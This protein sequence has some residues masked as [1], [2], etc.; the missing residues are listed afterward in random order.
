M[1]EI[2]SENSR[3]YII[4]EQIEFSDLAAFSQ[5]RQFRSEYVH[6]EKNIWV[7]LC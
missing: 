6:V 4:Q 5:I 2:S 1:H 3:L 7:I